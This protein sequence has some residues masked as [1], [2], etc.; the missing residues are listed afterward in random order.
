MVRPRDLNP[1]YKLNSQHPPLPTEKF[2]RLLVAPALDFLDIRL[3]K[4]L[5]QLCRAFF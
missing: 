4:T 3:W 5:H 1:L 2:F